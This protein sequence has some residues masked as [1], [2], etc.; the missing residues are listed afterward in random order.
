MRGY[1]AN[2]EGVNA[3]SGGEFSPQWAQRVT[4]KEERKLNQVAAR[5]LRFTKKRKRR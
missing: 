4:E 5:A 1:Y 3:M 2:S